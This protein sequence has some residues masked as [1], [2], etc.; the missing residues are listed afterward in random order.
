VDVYVRAAG[1][2]LRHVHLQDSD[3]YADRHWHPGEG[4]LPWRAIF[5]ALKALP[6]MPRLIIEVKDQ[7][8]VRKGAEHLA[9]IELAR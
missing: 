9:T 7:K 6:A 5:A 2:A 3:G 8:N 4:S 1:G